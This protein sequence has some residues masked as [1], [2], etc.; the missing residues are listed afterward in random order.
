MDCWLL[1]QFSRTDTL[2]TSFGGGPDVRED[3]NCLS[4]SSRMLKLFHGVISVGPLHR[5]TSTLPGYAC[6]LESALLM[7]SAPLLEIIR[8]FLHGQESVDST[9]EIKYWKLHS[10]NELFSKIENRRASRQFGDESR[11]RHR[12]P[13]LINFT[14]TSGRQGSW[15]GQRPLSDQR[16]PRSQ[17]S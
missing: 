4:S 10:K 15:L 2:F 12:C 7:D 13:Q 3:Y 11:C 5:A 17:E 1:I 6:L 16:K 9:I 14:S 8:Y